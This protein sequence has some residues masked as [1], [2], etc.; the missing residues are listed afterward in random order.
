[1]VFKK[2]PKARYAKGQHWSTQVSLKASV[3]ANTLQITH[4]SGM[5]WQCM[6]VPEGSSSAPSPRVRHLLDYN[7]SFRINCR[8]GF[9]HYSHKLPRNK[10]HVPTYLGSTYIAFKWAFVW[11]YTFYSVAHGFLLAASRIPHCRSQ[12]AHKRRRQGPSSAHAL[13]SLQS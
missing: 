8:S 13:T 2:V 12:V 7:F 3:R 6:E 5:F 9:M 10:V 11:L 4:R 1:M